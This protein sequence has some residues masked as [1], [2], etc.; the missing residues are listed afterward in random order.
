MHLQRRH[1]AKA[2]TAEIPGV[3]VRI[4]PTATGEARLA[5]LLRTL[6]RD[7]SRQLQNTSFLIQKTWADGSSGAM[8]TAAPRPH[9]RDNLSDSHEDRRSVGVVGS[10]SL[11]A[12]FDAMC[13]H[14]N[15]SSIP[16]DEYARNSHVSVTWTTGRHGKPNVLSSSVAT[17]RSQGN[18]ENCG[19]VASSLEPL[20]FPRS[21]H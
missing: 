5:L 6:Q 14:V 11:V 12:A 17:P 13:L 9:R 4:K 20:I 18:T 1:P 21:Y 2:L 7:S 19:V 10:D 3:R 8:A 15:K 16:R